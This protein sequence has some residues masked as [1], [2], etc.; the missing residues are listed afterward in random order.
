MTRFVDVLFSDFVPDRGGVPWPEDPGYLVDAD[1]A[2]PSVNGWLTGIDA[3]AVGTSFA[4]STVLA[5]HETSEY[6]FVGTTKE[7]WQTNDKGTTWNDVKQATYSA[8]QLDN[9]CFAQ[10]D[11]LV[12]ATNRLTF[13]QKKSIAS[14][15]SDPFT[16]LGGVTAGAAAASCAFRV[17]D[18]LVFGE[19]SSS[20]AT[21]VGTTA[22]RWSSLGDPEDYPEP[23]SA[24]ALSRQAG[25]QLLDSHYGIVVSGVGTE[26]YGLIFQQR[27]VTRMTYIGGNAVYQFD[28]INHEIG[29]GVPIIKGPN[30]VVSA[31]GLHYFANR[32]GV[33]ATDGTRIRNLTAGRV[34]EALFLNNLSHSDAMGIVT[35]AVHDPYRKSIYFLSTPYTGGGA[36]GNL[37]VLAYD[38]ELDRFY[39]LAN[40]TAVTLFGSTPWHTFG[41]A[42]DGLR[43]SWAVIGNALYR[44]A[45]AT[46]SVDL[47]TGFIELDPGYRVQLHA[48][49]ILGG[50]TSTPTIAYKAVD[51]PNSISVAQTGFTSM[52]AAPRG[53]KQTGLATG[54]YFAFRV[55]GAQG[56]GAVQRGLRVYFERSSEE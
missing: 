11:E 52:T 25:A 46:A 6:I 17:R 30:S 7:I 18:H 45:A 48:A 10:F 35:S 23:G 32:A 34:G 54:R 40:K 16:D 4:G 47:Q 26:R 38:Y 15:A 28:R 49:H 1:G 20:F 29:Q 51:T 13:P 50:G 41:A 37:R 31:N 21:N 14:P 53:I 24:T 43:S 44:F 39:F 12:V 33:F 55:T 8:S 2:R 19:L 5:A 36:F 22:V 42:I 9:W 27:A 56:V 3:T